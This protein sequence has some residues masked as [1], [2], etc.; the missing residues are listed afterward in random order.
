M[1]HSIE[2]IATFLG[3]SYTD[4]ELEKL[5]T[6]LKFENFRHNKS[7]NYDIMEKLGIVLKTEGGFV[8]KGK[9]GGWRDYFDQEMEKQANQWIEENLRDTDIRFPV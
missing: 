8:R 4:Q 9:N 6:H 3:K 2:K 5:E 1:R 7:V